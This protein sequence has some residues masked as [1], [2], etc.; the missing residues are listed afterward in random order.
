MYPPALIKRLLDL[1][2]DVPAGVDHDTQRF[3][4]SLGGHALRVAEIEERADDTS[5]SL[6]SPL[7]ELVNVLK[8]GDG[9]DQLGEARVAEPEQAEAAT[10]R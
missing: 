3:L 7:L 1:N 6:N 4:S 8:D 9:P 5:V 2:A 10:R